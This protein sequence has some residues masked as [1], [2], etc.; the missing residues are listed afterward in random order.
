MNEVLGIDVGG[1]GIKGAPVSLRTGKLLAE[2]FRLDTPQPATPDAVAET[3]AGVAKHFDWTGPI[4]V[5]FPAAIQHGIVRTASNID[6]SW[7]GIDAAALIGA[8]TGA[9]KV[10][11][12][13]DADVAGLAEIRFGAGKGVKGSVLMITI[14]TGIGTALFVDGKLV[15]NMEM[16]H[17]E[18]NG[19]DGEAWASDAARER[20][21]LKW[22]KWAGRIDKYLHKIEDLLWPDLIIVGGGV[23]K[24]AERFFPNLTVRTPIVPA[25]MLNEAG[26]VGA[27]L[28]AR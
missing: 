12:A 27:A 20:E 18:V 21:N 10:A 23:S 14:G 19:K 9:P 13:N 6:P 24:K 3:I 25:T 26:I 17:I 16:G 28:I 7:I 8:A 1:T 4:G 2:R 5:G 15:P 11:V 22:D